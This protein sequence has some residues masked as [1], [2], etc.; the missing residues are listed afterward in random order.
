MK[1]T[2]LE[3]RKNGVFSDNLS[4]EQKDVVKAWRRGEDVKLLACP[5][6]GK[7]RVIVACCE[8]SERRGET[9]VVLSYNRDLSQ[10]TK[11]LVEGMEGVK[12]F[13]FHSLAS[14]CCRTTPDDATL[15]DVIESMEKGLP[16]K[17]MKADNV[18]IDECQDF[19]PSFLRLIQKVLPLESAKMMVVGDERQMLYDYM[20]EDAADVSFLTSPEEKF[21][22]KRIF[23]E[24]RLTKSHRMTRSMASLLSSTFGV[25][26]GSGKRETESG[27]K[28][29]IVRTINVWAASQVVRPYLGGDTC[30]LVS[31]KKN[32]SPLKHMVNTLSAEGYAFQISAPSPCS[33]GREEEEKEKT[34]EGEKS[35][36][37][38][39]TWHSSKGREFKR[40]ILFGVKEEDFLSNPLFVAMSRGKEELILLLDESS[41]HKQI[42][43]AC[44][45]C[46]GEVETDTATSFIMR[47]IGK[48]SSSI[49]VLDSSSPPSISLLGEEVDEVDLDGWRCPDSGR[50][51]G[52]KVM[53][54][55]RLMEEEEAPY[56]S[57]VGKKEILITRKGMREDVSDVYLVAS[58]VQAEFNKT[59]KVKRF[60][61]MKR[62]FVMTK[63]KRRKAI[64]NGNAARILV[65]SSGSDPSSFS[66]LFSK[67]LPKG[68]ADFSRMGR[69]LCFLSSSFLSWNSFHHE[70][71]QRLPFDWLDV[72]KVSSASSFFLSL[73]DSDPSSSSSL[74]F[75][76]VLSR[77][78]DGI[79]VHCRCD[80]VTPS[81]SYLCIWQ[82]EVT[83]EHLNR[84]FFLSSLH[85]SGKCVLVNLST[86]EHRT[87][88]S[89][90]PDNVLLLS[91]RLRDQERKRRRVEDDSEKKAPKLSKYF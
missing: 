59:G 67:L 31:R 27:R 62:P 65:S 22:R 14:H 77:E 57:K 30:I 28:K 29:A 21:G 33:S 76:R 18:M 70:F 37:T 11:K 2:K 43:R 5:G 66:S 54:G 16:F 58:L 6:A 32:N 24:H 69:D 3:V 53:E 20:M 87:L 90:S 56:F 49:S 41:P 83:R 40:A 86:L 89:P 72:Q 26:I 4:E 36:T 50:W 64:L 63:E 84:A 71:W 17:K 19:R 91:S 10:D 25:E 13:T 68:A 34:G 35:K 47:G 38:I 48:E 88:L 45:S 8:E 44:F 1:Q 78:E 61:H 73:L 55:E 51:I 79:L 23:S 74:L 46:Q 52:G 85:P 42:L 39:S 60:L 75:D 80:A 12:C 7:T 82:Q 9:T 15:M 81:S